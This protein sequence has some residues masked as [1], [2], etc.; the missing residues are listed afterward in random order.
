MIRTAEV[1]R[2]LDSELVVQLRHEFMQFRE[3]K[4][5]SLHSTFEAWRESDHEDLV[6]S[7]VINVWW[8]LRTIGKP[9][10]LS[11][12]SGRDDSGIDSY[13]PLRF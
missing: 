11:D 9:R 10:Y 13:D 7:L 4:T 1:L 12:F 5:K 6:L 2:Q 8:I 3:K